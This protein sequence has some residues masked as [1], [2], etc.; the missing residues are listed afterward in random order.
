MASTS[1]STIHMPA[2][3]GLRFP[4]TFRALRHRNYRLWFF[5]QGI[6][7]IGTWMQNMAQ[8]VLVYRLT[9]SAAALGI[10]S[11]I[12]VLPL[13]PLSLWGGS[14]TDRFPKRTILLI[15][16]GVMLV[17]AFLL[18]VLTW[19]GTVQI[20]HVYVLAFVLGAAIA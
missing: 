16:Q 10:I 11:G 14:I 3:H 18:A 17:Q 13:I 12:G 19:I 5:G 15:T 7:L 4:T 6:S 9:G 8:Q 20:G 2:E 1:S